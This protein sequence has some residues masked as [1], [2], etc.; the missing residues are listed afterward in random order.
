VGGRIANCGLGLGQVD[1]EG[2]DRL[3]FLDHLERDGEGRSS[4]EDDVCESNVAVL[5][6]VL[7][8]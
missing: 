3:A 4:A 2:S 6:L 7:H 1:S 5:V 8:P